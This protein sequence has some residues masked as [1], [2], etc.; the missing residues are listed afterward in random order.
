MRYVV[1][2]SAATVLYL[3][4]L[5]LALASG[6]HYMVSILVAQ[7]LTIP[8][9][10]VAYRTVVFGPGASMRRD[11]RRFLS[12]WSG[13]AVAGLVGTPLLVELAG[14]DPWFAQLLTVAVVALGSFVLHLTYS[15]RSS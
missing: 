15:F 10:F 5:K 13:G 11:F 14:A 4:L 7:A 9:A 1:T 2:A 12:V 8:V 6:L 3:G